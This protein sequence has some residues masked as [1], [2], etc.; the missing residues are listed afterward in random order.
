[1][2]GQFVEVRIESGG[3]PYFLRRFEA[4]ETKEIRVY[5]H[6]GDDTATVTGRLGMKV[7]VI[8]GTASTS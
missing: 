5:L 8:G 3:P 6:G 4:R 7:R 1:V 2:D